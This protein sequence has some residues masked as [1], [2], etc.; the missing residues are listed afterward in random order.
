MGGE[1]E[2]GGGEGENTAEASESKRVHSMCLF[3]SDGVVQRFYWVL[4]RA[5][6]YEHG[7]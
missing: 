3:V 5:Q 4:I 7:S 6:T 1:E 2:R